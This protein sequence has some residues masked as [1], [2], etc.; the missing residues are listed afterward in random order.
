MKQQETSLPAMGTPSL[1]LCCQVANFAQDF[2]GWG[3]AVEPHQ[4]H[5]AQENEA[6]RAIA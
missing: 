4:N 1:Q 6:Q 3:A 5:S 2:K